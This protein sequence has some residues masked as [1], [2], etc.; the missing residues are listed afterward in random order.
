[1][2]TIEA[3]CGRGDLVLKS[4]LGLLVDQEFPAVSNE[5]RADVAVVVL[6]PGSRLRLDLALKAARAAAAEAG[7]GLVSV[8]H[9]GDEAVRRSWK[10]LV[11]L[12]ACVLLDE[13]PADVLGIEE[14][15]DTSQ[16]VRTGDP[17]AFAEESMPHATKTL[18]LLQGVE[19]AQSCE[20]HDK[21]RKDDVA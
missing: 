7:R 21:E 15:L 12:E 13:E 9:Q 3:S 8:E 16:G 18:G 10:R 4:P 20:Q 17:L 19:A 11:S 5:Q 14:G 6:R 2:D 1:M